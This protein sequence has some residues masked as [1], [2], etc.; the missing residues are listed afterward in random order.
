MKKEAIS[1]AGLGDL[2]VE[3]FKARLTEDGQ[4]KP[5]YKSGLD[6]NRIINRRH[7]SSGGG[8]HYSSSRNNK[9]PNTCRGA[10]LCILPA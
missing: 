9:K 7:Y 2:M 4:I 8:S 3:R 6:I 10:G 5:L 1:F